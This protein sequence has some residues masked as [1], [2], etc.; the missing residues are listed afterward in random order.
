[1]KEKDLKIFKR[2]RNFIVF[3]VEANGLLDTVSKIHCFSYEKYE[4]FSLVDKKT[5]FD[6]EEISNFFKNNEDFIFI[7]HNIIRFDIILLKKFG[8][9]VP[10]SLFLIDTLAVSWYLESSEKKHGLEY[11]GEEFENEKI[12]ILDWENLSLEDYKRRCQRDVEINVELFD[13]QLEKLISLYNNEDLIINLINYL[14]FKFNCL[15]EQE[16]VGIPLDIYNCNKYKLDTEFL[17][18]EKE[19]TLSNLMPKE[20]G[21]VIKEKPKVLYKKDNSLSSNGESWFNYIKEHN[22]DENIDCIREKPNPGST[23]QLKD[24]LFSLGW[25][26]DT[27]KISKSTGEQVP[28]VSLPFGGGISF[29]IKNLYEKEPNLKELENLFM[30]RHRFGLFKSFIE[31]EKNG[32]IYSTA[33]G[34]T[35]TLRLKHSKPCANL[36]G[37]EKPYGT[38]IRG[39]LKVPDDSYIMCGFDVSGL[40]DNTK[41]HYIYYFD[42]E[43]VKEMRV[44]G[45]DPHLDIALLAGLLTQEEVNFYKWFDN[46]QESESEKLSPEELTDSI[47]RFKRIKG[48]RHIA[49]TSNFAITYN[50][51]PPKIAETAKISIQEAQH[52]FNIY[53][54]RNKAIKRVVSNC[55]IK[56]IKGDYWVKNPISGIWLYLKEEKDT[57][58]TVNQSSGVYVFDTLLKCIKERLYKLKIPI[59]FQYHDEGLMYF[60]KE[61]KEE[62]KKII[63]DSVMQMNNTLKLNIEIKVSISFGNNYADCH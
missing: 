13:N 45:F 35:N 41:Q 22:L 28:Q 52:L 3:D 51:F 30:L 10:D 46:L 49:K 36:P 26:P 16:E 43:Y 12:E 17:I 40:E 6:L 4:N 53:W 31:K 9:L 7:G 8:I 55:E 20:L 42:P 1:M 62:V 63:D 2:L 58:S 37:V 57:F 34:F 19:A 14:T 38:E 48:I 21:K 33:H 54:E 60:H 24:W 18:K 23:K 50:A 29:S 11:Y 59:V 61:Y 39:I 15:K 56:N 5:L 44:P 47:T 27:F 25:E 32:F